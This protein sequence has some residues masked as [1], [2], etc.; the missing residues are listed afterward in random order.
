MAGHIA[1][2][3]REQRGANAHAQFAS[4]L[5]AVLGCIPCHSTAHLEWCYGFSNLG[6][7]TLTTGKEINIQTHVQ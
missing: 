5:K 2:A 7:G 6:C 4:S 3:V 1:S